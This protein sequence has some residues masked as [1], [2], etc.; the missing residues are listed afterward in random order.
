M[1]KHFIFSHSNVSPTIR[2]TF[3][4]AIILIIVF[5]CTQPQFKPHE[6]A[7]NM[8]FQQRVR[9]DTIAWTS[10]GDF[11]ESNMKIWTK[12]HFIFVGRATID[13]TIY[14]HYGGGTYTLDGNRYV[15]TIVYFDTKSSIGTKNKMLLEVRGDSLIL[16]WPADDNWQID[17]SN[18]HVE[19]Y[20][21]AE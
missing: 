14:D 11:T 13:T 4:I 9:A 19:K 15:E 18:Y 8:V 10:P 12:D 3:V 5:S 7:W 16:T 6:G 17:K 20:V 21:R 1:N 2:T